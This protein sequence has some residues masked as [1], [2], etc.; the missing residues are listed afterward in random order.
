MQRVP[1]SLP[2]AETCGRLDMLDHPMSR[3]ALLQMRL[4]MKF[5]YVYGH[6]LERRPFITV[7]AAQC[8]VCGTYL[9]T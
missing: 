2:Q 1:L 4:E 7:C 9:V 5:N 6:F 8:Q 3:Q